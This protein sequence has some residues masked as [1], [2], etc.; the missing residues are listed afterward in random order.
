LLLI[1]CCLLLKQCESRRQQV[2]RQHA[3]IP[4]G[5]LVHDG[6]ARAELVDD[7]AARA[8]RRAGNVLRVRHGDGTNLDL[9]SF[10]GDGLEDGGALGAVRQAVRRVLDVAS[11]VDV[12]GLGEQRRADEKLEYGA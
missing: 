2:F 11:G 12:A 1:A 3:D 4:L 9:R 7:L 8:A 10:F 5:A 6:C